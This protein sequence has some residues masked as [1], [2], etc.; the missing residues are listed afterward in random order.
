MSDA[1]LRIPGPDM[2]DLI[3][4]VTGKGKSFRFQAGGS[5]M[6]PFIK[7]GDV[8]TVAPVSD[9]RVR[10]GEVVA[11]RRLGTDRLSV[12]RI[13][14]KA[15][16]NYLIQ[17]DNN[18]QPDGLVPEANIIGRITNIERKG[19]AITFGL[20]PERAIVAF[21]VRAKMLP[22]S[23][24]FTIKIAHPILI[25]L[26]HGRQNRIGYF[27]GMGISSAC[28]N[29][30]ASLIG[31]IQHLSFYKKMLSSI[32]AGIKIGYADEGENSGT[33]GLAETSQYKV[34]N[35]TAR[36]RKNIIGFVQL[37]FRN[38]DSH[39]YDGFWIHAMNVRIFYRGLGLGTELVRLVVQKAREENAEKI[40]LLVFENNKKAIGLYKKAGFE[41]TTI[42]A[43]ED[44]L[45]KEK[46]VRGCRRIAMVKQ[47]QAHE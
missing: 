29:M 38:K 8:L 35:L 14:G 26:R 32:G 9:G 34:W 36:K 43:L 18:Y 21:L 15:G 17:G 11:F 5:S 31:R 33:G 19:R 12:H 44:A 30:T 25:K 39:P 47:L 4:A 3:V 13:V 23:L 45:E 41:M 2:V 10:V 37:V 20:G 27:L 22:Q 42:D 40:Y 1:E 16:C 46:I 28:K 6:Y 7:D 24:R